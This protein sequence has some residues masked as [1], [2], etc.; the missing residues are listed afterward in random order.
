MAPDQLT[1]EWAAA[2]PAEDAF[3]TLGSMTTGLTSEEARLRLDRDGPNA[4][5]TTGS[6][7][8]PC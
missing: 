4:V 2:V 1:R 6:A 7:R 8:G 5:R 3:T